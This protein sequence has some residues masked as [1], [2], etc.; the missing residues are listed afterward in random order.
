MTIRVLLAAERSM[1]RDALR[2]LIDGQED[3]SLAG[4][5]C[6]HHLSLADFRQC[7][8]DVVLVDGR[9]LS[10]RGIDT[11][12]WLADAQPECPIVLIAEAEDGELLAE[13]LESGASGFLCEGGEL[14]DVVAGVRAVYRGET[15]VPPAML[16]R[17]LSHLIRRRRQWRE[18]LRRT[19]CLTQREREV[20]ALIAEGADT[21]TIATT[22]VIA[23]HTARTHVQRVLTKLGM[24]SRLEAATFVQTNA[25]ITDLASART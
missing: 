17:L 4:E 16:G 15:V 19:S 14:D 20:L 18:A 10:C 2:I 21:A 23:H 6:V 1:L 8:P 12:A 5:V 24:H 9:S 3:L 22:L 11:V 13:A 25:L 7:K